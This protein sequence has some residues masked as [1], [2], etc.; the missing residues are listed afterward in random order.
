MRKHIQYFFLKSISF[1]LLFTLI[2]ICSFIGGSKL[3][4]YIFDYTSDHT[5][6][7]L[8]Y[9]TMASSVIALLATLVTHIFC[10][11]VL[12]KTDFTS[13]FRTVNLLII[14][15]TGL[16]TAIVAMKSLLLKNGLVTGH[17]LIFQEQFNMFG[18]I[19]FIALFNYNIYNSL[20]LAKDILGFNVV[21]AF[22]K[23]SLRSIYTNLLYRIRN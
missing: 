22:I 21:V 16:G 6:R 7:A 17:E 14:Y 13:W 15:F 11:F 10:H 8:V 2:S 23:K 12:K 19:F 20:F 18:V 4:E 5:I 9:G 1:S 3:I